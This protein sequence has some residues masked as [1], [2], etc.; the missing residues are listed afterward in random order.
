M[1]NGEF[2]IDGNRSG[3]QTSIRKTETAYDF[4]NIVPLWHA[5][6]TSSLIPYNLQTEEPMNWSQVFHPKN[7]HQFLLLFLENLSII[8]KDHEIIDIEGDNAEFAGVCVNEY[9]IIWTASGKPDLFEL[10]FCLLIPCAWHLFESIE[11]L[12]QLL[13]HLLTTIVKT[14]R[15]RPHVDQV[16]KI[17]IEEGCLNVHLMDFQIELCSNGE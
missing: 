15:R 14:P 4:S 17:T 9:G 12:L 13:H 10:N 8:R 11:T 6:Q 1:E 7:S 2:K 3:G 16:F 5:N